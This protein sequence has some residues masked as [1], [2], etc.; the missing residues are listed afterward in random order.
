[1]ARADDKRRATRTRNEARPARA[2]R[3]PETGSFSTLFA[4]HQATAVDS[5]LRLVLDPIASLLTWAVIGI[6]LALPLCLLL[7]LQNL[8]QVGTNLEQ[9]G[10]LSLFME[11]DVPAEQIADVQAT[12]T[13][14]PGIA[15]VDLLTAD[16]AL[17]EF[18]AA[19]GF[20]DLLNGLDENP[21]PAV[22]LV[23]PA[24][25]IDI[26]ILQRELGAMRGV[27]LAQVD[28]EWVQRL[29]AL[30]S[31]AARLALLLASMLCIGVI[32][33]IGNTVR[34]AIENRRA[35]I[36]VVKLVGGTDAYVSRP[37]LY[38]GLWYGVGG[39]LLA[40][41]L[42]ALALFA[43]QGP[44][45]NLMQTWNGEFRL[46]GLGISNSFFVLLGAGLLGWLG[47]WVSVMRHLRAIEP[48]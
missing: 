22:F 28:L 15:A 45:S 40:V 48:R 26:A 24:D 1:V 5:L 19:S 12:L 11:Q 8:Q 42:I 35:E 33:V 16:E 27:E 17:A 32:L 46:S 30:V 7:L 39:G 43:L 14:H 3:A 36:V 29:N 13:A 2:V 41:L 44:V 18:E 34:L 47:A 20:G 21:L 10:G 4:Q 38:T 23:T 6:A 9:S 37:F 31:L 25:D